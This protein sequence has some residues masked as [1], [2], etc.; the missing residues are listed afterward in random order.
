[1]SNQ[2]DWPGSDEAADLYELFVRQLGGVKLVDPEPSFCVLN[3]V[4]DL[5][6]KGRRT[7]QR[8]LH[9]SVEAIARE[10]KVTAFVKVNVHTTDTSAGYDA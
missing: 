5:V 7:D 9:V 1:M 4:L 2:R 8:C 6:D 3:V 10:R